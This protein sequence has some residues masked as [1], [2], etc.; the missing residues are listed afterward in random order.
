MSV[1]LGNGDGTFQDPTAIDLPEYAPAVSLASGDFDGDG[2]GDLALAATSY[3]MARKASFAC[4]SATA[5]GPSPRRSTR[6][7]RTRGLDMPS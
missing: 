4:T 2:A 1:A 6:C 5:T 3:P 7:F